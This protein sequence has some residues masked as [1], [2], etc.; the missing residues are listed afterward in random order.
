MRYKVGTFKRG[1]RHRYE[2]PFCC[3]SKCADSIN[4]G[5][6]QFH[7]EDDIDRGRLQVDSDDYSDVGPD[8]ED[9]TFFRLCFFCRGPLPVS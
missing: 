4:D 1:E 8:H 6:F 9:F 5:V 2:G 3:C 7:G